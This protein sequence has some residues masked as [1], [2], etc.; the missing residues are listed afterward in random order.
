MAVT[1]ETNKYARHQILVA[2]P[3]SVT[4]FFLFAPWYIHMYIPT[5]ALHHEQ[6]K[7]ENCFVIGKN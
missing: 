3:H 6:I 2:I 1:R 5:T 4:F 7:L